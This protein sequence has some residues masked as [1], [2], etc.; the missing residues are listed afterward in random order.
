MQDMVT[1]INVLGPDRPEGVFGQH[2]VPR[3]VG[4]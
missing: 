3:Y 1:G 2:R 4:A